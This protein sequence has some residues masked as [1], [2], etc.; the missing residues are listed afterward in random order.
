MKAAPSHSASRALL[1]PL[2]LYFPHLLQLRSWEQHC[3]PPPSS[4]PLSFL[5]YL[6]VRSW[7][8]HSEFAC[9]LDFSMLQEGLMASAGWDESAWL[10]HQSEPMAMP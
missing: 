1:P 6:Q 9:G 10:W 3:Y 5:H 8:H 4:I 7:E 2:P